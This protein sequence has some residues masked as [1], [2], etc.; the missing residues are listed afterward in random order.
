MFWYQNRSFLFIY[1]SLN[2]R[3]QDKQKQRLHLMQNNI[4]KNK[5]ND[6]ATSVLSPKLAE[7]N[8]I[9]GLF[10]PSQK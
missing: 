4:H 1:I 2:N 8:P 10:T 3:Q 9:P 5:A 6:P 7:S